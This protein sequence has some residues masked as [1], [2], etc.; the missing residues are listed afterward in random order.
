MNKVNIVQQCSGWV[1]ITSKSIIFDLSRQQ[2]DADADPDGVNAES[3]KSMFV[4]TIF[5]I[6]KENY[7]K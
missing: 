7:D 2:F 6:V 3:V 5:E 4:S 1:M